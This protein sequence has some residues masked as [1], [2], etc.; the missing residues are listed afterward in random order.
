MSSA[1]TVDLSHNAITSLAGKSA[2]AGLARGGTVDL[3]YNRLTALKDPG[4]LNNAESSHLN[5]SHNNITD[6]QKGFFKTDS[7]AYLFS[8][9]LSYNPLTNISEGAFSSYWGGQ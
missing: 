2:S 4:V 1:K 9:D 5:F 3:S 8:I 6:I 7:F